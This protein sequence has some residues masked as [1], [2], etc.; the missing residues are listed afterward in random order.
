MGVSMK[1]ITNPVMPPAARR[2]VAQLVEGVASRVESD[3]EF[4]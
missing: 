3:C 2:F 4:K 1:E